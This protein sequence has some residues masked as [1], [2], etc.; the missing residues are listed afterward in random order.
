MEIWFQ[1]VNADGTPQTMKDGHG[2]ERPMTVAAESE[3]QVEEYRKRKWIEMPV[4][5]GAES[6]IDEKAGAEITEGEEAST[7]IAPTETT[8]DAGGAAKEHPQYGGSPAETAEEVAAPA[9]TTEEAAAPPKTEEL[10]LLAAPSLKE[11]GKA[12]TSSRNKQK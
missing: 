7:T 3:A 4:H 1:I 11:A 10:P 12:V 2:N 6:G 8:Q 5:S 9:V